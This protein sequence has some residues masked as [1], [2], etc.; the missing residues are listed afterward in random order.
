MANESL[1]VSQPHGN[2]VSEIAYLIETSLQ[3]RCDFS[4]EDYPYS[5]YL[6]ELKTLMGLGFTVILAEGSRVRSCRP[7]FAT[8]LRYRDFI[9]HSD[10][11]S[12]LAIVIAEIICSAIRPFK[13]LGFPLYYDS[14]VNKLANLLKSHGIA[15]TEQEKKVKKLIQQLFEMCS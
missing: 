1:A 6:R 14:F 10:K 4:P 12:Q 9:Q 5:D 3:E 11:L 13:V 8:F 2:P 15:N 7:H